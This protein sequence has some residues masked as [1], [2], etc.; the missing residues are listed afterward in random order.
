MILACH[1]K[2]RGIRSVAPALR[3]PGLGLGEVVV[4]ALGAVLG[5][6]RRRQQRHAELLHRRRC[7]HSRRACA[8]QLP[9][10]MP[11]FLSTQDHKQAIDIAAHMQASNVF[12]RPW[13]SRVLRREQSE[14]YAH[15]FPTPKV[16]SCSAG[17][18][19][20]ALRRRYLS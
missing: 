7:A 16:A 5:L 8:A 11:T 20:S 3:R 4:Q 18:T 14:S 13:Y 2:M 15:I 10:H 17:A 6:G 1:C 12:M 9:A 19:L